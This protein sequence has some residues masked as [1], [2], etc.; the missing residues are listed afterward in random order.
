MT[1]SLAILCHTLQYYYGSHEIDLEWMFAGSLTSKD[2]IGSMAADDRNKIDVQ[3]DEAVFV[4][5][6]KIDEPPEVAV[7][8]TTTDSTGNTTTIDAIATNATIADAANVTD[9]IVTTVAAVT[10]TNVTTNATPISANTTANN[11]NSTNSSSPFQLQSASMTECP[12]V[13][14]VLGMS[15]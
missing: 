14:P 4:N 12:A 15:E 5:E 6:N 11:T 2:R 13:P 7:A 10:R 9:A 3:A 8:T 1:T